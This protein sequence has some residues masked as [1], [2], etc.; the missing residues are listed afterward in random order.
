[1]Q[2]SMLELWLR[3]LALH[4]PEPTDGGENS[5]TPNIRDQW[6]LASRGYFTGCVPHGLE[7]ACILNGGKA[8]MRSAI[9][10]VL[11]ALQSTDAPLEPATLNLLGIEGHFTRP[12]ERIW[13]SDIGNAFLDLLDGN[14]T[15]DSSSAE[16]MPGSTPYGRRA[17]SG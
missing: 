4:L 6:L 14:V 7:D 12:I 16:I 10:S 5:A 13:L 8:A 17:T 2:D 3:L 9:A 15:C 1:M 11:G